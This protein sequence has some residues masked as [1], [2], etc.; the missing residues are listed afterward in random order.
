MP[1]GLYQAERKKFRED[2][3]TTGE[4]SGRREYVGQ[5]CREILADLSTTTWSVCLQVQEKTPDKCL[6][7]N[8]QGKTVAACCDD[9]TCRVVE[10]DLTH[11][12]KE[13]PPYTGNTT[14]RFCGEK[15]CVI[16]PADRPLCTGHLCAAA[17]RILESPGNETA[18]QTWAE[19]RRQDNAFQFE[20]MII[21]IE[22]DGEEAFLER[23]ATMGPSILPENSS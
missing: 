12:H 10:Q 14:A 22:M 5:R 2:Y 8:D 11:A 9:Q 16:D 20:K 7:T 15:G 13:V 4:Q 17:Q 23:F 19:L 21:S 3:P 1:T 18:C 6:R